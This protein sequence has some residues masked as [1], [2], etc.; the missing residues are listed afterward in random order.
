MFLTECEEYQYFKSWHGICINKSET[1]SHLRKR[2]AYGEVTAIF[3]R[4]FIFNFNFLK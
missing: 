4:K 2:C 3:S 1:S